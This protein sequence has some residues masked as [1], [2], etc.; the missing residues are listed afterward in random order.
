MLPGHL[1]FPPSRQ[2]QVHGVVRT[3][4]SAP[5]ELWGTCGLIWA[6]R[7]IVKG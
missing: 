1:I 5:Q 3:R 7:L 4:R 6:H 2:G